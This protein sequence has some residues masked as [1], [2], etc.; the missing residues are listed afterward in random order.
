MISNF[1]DFFPCGFCF[2]DNIINKIGWQGAE[3]LNSMLEVD[4]YNRITV[5][6]A[7]KHPFF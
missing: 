3:L 5:K 1:P 4:P 7:L 2:N 6:N